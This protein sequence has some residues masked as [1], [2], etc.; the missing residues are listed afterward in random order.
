MNKVLHVTKMILSQEQC[1]FIVKQ[2][3][4][5]HLLKCV[6]ADFIQ[7]FPN[8]VSPSNNA[9]LN[10]MKKIENKCALHDLPQLGCLSVVT[11]EKRE[12]IA[13]NVTEHPAISSKW[14]MQKVGLSHI[15]TYHTLYSS[16]LIQN[17]N[18]TRVK[19]SWFTKKKQFVN[20]LVFDMFFFSDEVWFHLDGYINVQNYHVKSWRTLMFYEE[21]YCIPQKLVF[22]EPRV[23][24]L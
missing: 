16:L 23:A 4:G 10:L 1:A 18:S 24:N 12:A 8:S 3:Y 22:N 9:I 20:V 19:V 14:L 13:K 17:F 7:E 6:C 21:G 5:T 15:S 2:Y 11:T